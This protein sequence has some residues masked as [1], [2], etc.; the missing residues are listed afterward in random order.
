MVE[1]D[2]VVA[3]NADDSRHF[4][5]SS[6]NAAAIILE[7]AARNSILD[8]IKECGYDNI[9]IFALLVG[10]AV[11]VPMYVLDEK[12]VREDES[13]VSATRETQETTVTSL[14]RCFSETSEECEI[15]EL[16]LRKAAI[17]N[18]GIG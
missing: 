4:T 3:T 12:L 6:K 16:A 7:A 18:I 5:D 8:I 11:R 13:V 2:C 15:E 1:A 14:P 17:L 10:S 9:I